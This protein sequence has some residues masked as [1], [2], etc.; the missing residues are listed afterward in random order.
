MGIAAAALMV[1]GIITTASVHAQT[2]DQADNRGPQNRGING[3]NSEQR[4]AILEAIENNDYNAWKELVG[5]R[6]IADQINES[7]FAKFVEMHQL[8]DQ[9]RQ[10]GQELGLKGKPGPGMGM[11]HGFNPDKLMRGKNKAY[12]GECPFAE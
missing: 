2:S 3:P 10:I 8:I 1:A 7:N 12:N 5:D 11:G 4:Q 9:A 6:P